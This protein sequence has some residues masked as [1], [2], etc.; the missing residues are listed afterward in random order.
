MQICNI[1]QNEIPV[2]VLPCE[3]CEICSNIFY[4]EHHQATASDHSSINS[5]NRGIDKQT[6]TNDAEIKTYQFEP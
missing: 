2:Q 6:V 4:L 5:S 1:F 3:F